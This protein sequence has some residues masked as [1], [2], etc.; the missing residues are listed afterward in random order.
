MRRGNK[1]CHS[2]LPE[3]LAIPA[4]HSARLEKSR[5]T[6]LTDPIKLAKA[7]A[8]KTARG[9]GQLRFKPSRRLR[10]ILCP[11]PGPASNANDFVIG[12]RLRDREPETVFNDG[13]P[14]LQ[15]FYFT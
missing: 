10:A 3:Q 8:N 14:P 5:S 2:A 12:Q 6:Y 4:G 7:H 13:T 15:V 11:T 1:V 9:G